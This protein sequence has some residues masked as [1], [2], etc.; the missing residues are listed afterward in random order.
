MKYAIS[1]CLGHDIVAAAPGY[2]AACAL[3]E[4][5]LDPQLIPLLYSELPEYHEEISDGCLSWVRCTDLVA[6]EYGHGGG[7]VLSTIMAEPYTGY[8]AFVAALAEECEWS[9]K[10]HGVVDLAVNVKGRELVTHQ[11]LI[12]PWHE[13][14]RTFDVRGR[15]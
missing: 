9:H 2:V 7:C 6:A 5:R 14:L 12:E 11:G 3:A 15:I 4:D 8:P 13:E 10:Y 1:I